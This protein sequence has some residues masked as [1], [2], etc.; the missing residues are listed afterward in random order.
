MKELSWKKMKSDD[1]PGRRGA[2]VCLRIELIELVMGHI[3]HPFINSL[4]TQEDLI[5]PYVPSIM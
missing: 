5:G 1:V 3:K 2:V 4:G